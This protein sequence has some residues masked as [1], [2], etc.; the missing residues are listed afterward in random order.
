MILS[1]ITSILF[2]LLLVL[3][4]G[5]VALSLVWMIGVYAIVLGIILAL[6]L[7]SVQSQIE[8]AD[9]SRMAHT[10]GQRDRGGF[11]FILELI[12][13]TGARLQPSASC[14]KSCVLHSSNVSNRD[15]TGR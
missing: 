7:R 10:E 8:T 6:R 9:A 13:A 3:F 11:L 1:G 15:G 2:G 12:G 4:Q 5:A 14:D